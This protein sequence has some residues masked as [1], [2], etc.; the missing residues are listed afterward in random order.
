MPR[1]KDLSAQEFNQQLA[2]HAF[3][4]VRRG[5]FVDL[6]DPARPRPLIDA[7]TAGR[8]ISRSATLA[9]LLEARA[10]RLTAAQAAAARQAER[11]RVAAAIAP[12]ALP[13]PRAEL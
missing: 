12:V 2:L 4:E 5:L 8:R 1:R 10:V 6:R 11:E 13:P 9:A 7:I 3:A